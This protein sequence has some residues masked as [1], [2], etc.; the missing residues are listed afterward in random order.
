MLGGKQIGDGLVDVDRHAEIGEL[1]RIGVVIIVFD[2]DGGALYRV[3]DGIFQ[4]LPGLPGNAGTGEGHARSGLILK[5]PTCNEES[6]DGSEQHHPHHDEGDDQ[7]PLVFSLYFRHGDLFNRSEHRRCRRKRCDRS[8]IVSSQGLLTLVRHAAV[9]Y[10][11]P[12]FTTTPNYTPCD[13]QFR[14]RQLVSE[15]FLNHIPC[16]RCLAW[17]LHMA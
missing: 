3:A 1:C 14:S 7:R 12:L 17:S 2:G 13:D 4:L 16:D 15:P 10:I 8:G 6:G 9:P 5:I 11:L